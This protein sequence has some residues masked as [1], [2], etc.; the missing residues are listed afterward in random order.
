[1]ALWVCH[2]SIC[3]P[4]LFSLSLSISISLFFFLSPISI[5]LTL[6]SL[7]IFLLLY[8]RIF[9]SCNFDACVCLSLSFSLSG[10]S[11]CRC[12]SNDEPQLAIFKIVFF[13][14]A[15]FNARFFLPLSVRLWGHAPALPVADWMRAKI[16]SSSSP[17]LL[18]SA[19]LILLAMSFSLPQR[20]HSNAGRRDKK[21][22]S[23]S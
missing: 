22:T 10:C 19:P 20:I 11:W 15:T 23:H 14:S 5:L 8:P 2:C 9:D 4:L 3:L 17:C 13:L 16:L 7:S 21:T 6:F 18:L 12:E 1:M